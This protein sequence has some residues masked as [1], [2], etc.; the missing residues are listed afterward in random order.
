MPEEG[1][2]PEVE[3]ALKQL[4]AQQQAQEPEPASPEPPKP[5]DELGPALRR[6]IEAVNHAQEKQRQAM[7]EAEQQAAVA[8]E[9]RDAWL[10][11]TPGAKQNIRALGILHRAALDA[12]FV[13]TSPEYFDFMTAQLAALQAPPP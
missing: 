12:G 13:D 8:K 1:L 3:D 6:Q 7:I 9:R 11:R 4:A 5:P 2:T 10:E